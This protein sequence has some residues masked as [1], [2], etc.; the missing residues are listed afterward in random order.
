MRQ[1]FLKPYLL[2]TLL[3]VAVILYGSLYPFTLHHRPPGASAWAALLRT[4]EEPF[5]GRG[6]L[7]AN[8]LLYMPFGLFA[9]LAVTSRL[10]PWRRVALVTLG[11]AALSVAVELAQF[12]IEDRVTAMSD[13]YANTLGSLLG[14]ALGTLL[15]GQRRWLPLREVAARPYPAL[16]LAAWLGDV[17]YP[18]V[19]VIDLHKYWRAVQPVVLTPSLGSYELFQR[20]V[21]WLTL[22]YIVA[23]LFGRARPLLFPLL[24]AATLMAK[25]LIVDRVVTLPEIVGALAACALWLG[26]VQYLPWRAA[27]LAL[28]LGALL[29]A[30]R[31]EP[32]H[33]SAQAHAFNWMPFHS[34]LHGSIETNIQSL[35]WKFFLYGGLIWLLTEAGLRLALAG[36]LTVIL[37]FATAVMQTY[38]PDRSAEITDC[39]IAL[40]AVIVQKLVAGTAARAA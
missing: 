35:L 27:F 40:A 17:L 23:V 34:L 6:D 38:L 29:V 28:A 33:P 18:Y 31:L 12:R 13:V 10:A 32:F 21:V 25:I 3:V 11:G 5:G 9:A 22:C 26:V 16:L 36:S 2:V 24:A 37:L 14:G 39:V 19:P 8:I 7:I 20:T 30:L 1:S 15:D 4:W